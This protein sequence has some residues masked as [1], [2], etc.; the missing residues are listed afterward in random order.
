MRRQRSK[1]CSRKSRYSGVW[2]AAIGPNPR[3]A[4]ARPTA[5]PP[6]RRRAVARP[7][8]ASPDWVAARRSTGTPSGRVASVRRRRRLSFSLRF[9]IGGI[10]Q[11]CKFL[12]VSSMDLLGIGVH[13]AQPHIEP[14][15]RAIL[16][17]D[18]KPH[19][20]AAL[21][22]GSARRRAA[23][24]CRRRAGPESAPRRKYPG[25]R[26]RYGHSRSN[27]YGKTGTCRHILQRSRRPRPRSPDRGPNMCRS[28]VGHGA[29]HLVLFLHMAGDIE[30][31]AMDAI[32]VGLRR[33]PHRYR[34][35]DVGRLRFRRPRHRAGPRV[36]SPRRMASSA[37]I[38]LSAKTRMPCFSSIAV[39]EPRPATR[40]PRRC[41]H[42]RNCCRRRDCRPS[43]AQS[44]SRC[45]APRRAQS[46][47]PPGKDR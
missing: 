37:S 7:A 36:T 30:E 35:F 23:A 1:I 13:E 20:G 18:G 8:P 32:E 19:I 11:G 21:A 42:R 40:L 14:H 16:R 9:V 27:S 44:G 31:R 3:S 41:R 43:A 34:R 47:Q 39:V 38:S 4:D 45:A 24:A 22:N 29:V 2:M 26:R 10:G 6:A 5:P 12:A 46:L 28:Q 25:R 33:T 17:V 15:R